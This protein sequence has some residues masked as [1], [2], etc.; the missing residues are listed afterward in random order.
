MGERGFSAIAEE[1]QICIVY[2]LL[3]RQAGENETSMA[4]GV[5]FTA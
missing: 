5:S 1:D 2:I 3:F 4:L